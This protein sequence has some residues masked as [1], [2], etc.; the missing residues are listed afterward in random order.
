MNAEQ[1]PR[2]V[3]VTGGARSI[4]K[5]IAERFAASGATVVVADLNAEAAAVTAAGLGNGSIGFGCDVTDRASVTEMFDRIDAEL[6]HLDVIVHNV[7]VAR[8]ISFDETTDDDWNFQVGVTLTAAFVVAQVGMPRLTTPGGSIVF[9]GSVNGAAA[10]GHEA[11]SAAKAGIVSLS[12]NLTLRYGPRGLRSNVVSPGT[13][14][15]DAWTPRIE[16]DPE[17]MTRMARHYPLGRVGTSED[18]AGAVVFL[19]SEEASWI[20]GVVLPVDGG[21]LAGNLLVTTD[22]DLRPGS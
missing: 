21:L 10:F 6:G 17:V 14:H 2:V 3:L 19:A 20:S 7:G 4:G 1:T 9:I 5:A 22:R 15:T 16:Q 8:D 18:V 11:Y 12:Q 13:I